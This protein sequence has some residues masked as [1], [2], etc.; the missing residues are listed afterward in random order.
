M[1]VDVLAISTDDVKTLRAFG[2]SQEIGYRLLSD[3]DASAARRFGV[4]ME[5]HPYA[6]RVTFVVAPGG[7]LRD[8]DREVNVKTHG[9]DLVARVRAFQEADRS[10]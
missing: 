7:T 6:N 5:D 10:K 8:V 2:E 1:G 3:A 4:L 9:D